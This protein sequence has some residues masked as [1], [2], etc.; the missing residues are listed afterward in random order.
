MAFDQRH[1]RLEPGE[2][3]DLPVTLGRE[4]VPHAGAG[5]KAIGGVGF[6]DHERVG[7]EAKCYLGW[8]S[9]LL[10]ARVGPVDLATLQPLRHVHLFARHAAFVVMCVLVALAVAHRLHQAGRRVAQ[11]HRNGFVAGFLDELA[12][13]AVRRQRGVRLR[14]QSQVERG[15]GEREHRFR[16]ADEVGRLLRGHRDGERLGVGQPDVL[17]REDDEPASDE[18]HVLAR[19]QHPC[20][21]VDSR[22]GVAAADALDQRGDDVV[23]LV[24]GAVVQE[25]ALLQRLL[26]VFERDRLLA[27]DQHYDI[28]SALI[29]SVRG[30]DPDAAV[31][32]MA[33]MLEAGE[34]VMFVARRLVILAAEDVGLADPRALSVAMAAQ[35][36]AHFVGMPEAV[37]PLTEAALYLALA[38]KSNSALTSYGAAR[39]LIQETGNEP[40]PL[41]LRN[42]PTGLMKSMG[43]G[44]GYKYAPDHE[45]GVAD[46]VHM[47]EKLKGRKVYK[48]NPRD[49][50][51]AK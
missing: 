30:S 7:H 47:P 35:Q 38:P 10:V 39:E 11:V 51:A 6:E 17:G 2:G 1:R 31:Y 5:G 24:A 42:A 20:H 27:G 23:V 45:G 3:F 14:G 8:E 32:W 50:N 21:P 15:F 48:P 34:D 37:L 4:P 28:V 41:H 12:R 33:R 16:H 22:V 19:L 9:G 44:K 40:V 29:K 26:D 25:V 36:A 49:K 46:Q 43:Y 18:H 13:S